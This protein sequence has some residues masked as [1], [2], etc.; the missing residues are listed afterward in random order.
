MQTNF[1]RFSPCKLDAHSFADVPLIQ[2][3]RVHRHG[4][5]SL[6]DG[7]NVV[8]GTY[9]DKMSRNRGGGSH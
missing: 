3:A 5:S 2:S 8:E 9:V 4:P 1:K 7:G 6:L